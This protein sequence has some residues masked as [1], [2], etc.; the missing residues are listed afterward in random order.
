MIIATKSSTNGKRIQAEAIKVRRSSS[1][2]AG[3]TSKCPRVKTR[4]RYSRSVRL[5]R[6]VVRRIQVRL[7]V[8]LLILL[9]NHWAWAE[10]V[11]RVDPLLRRCGKLSLLIRDSPGYDMIMVEMVQQELGIKIHLVPKPWKR[12][13]LE[14]QS[15]LVMVSST[16]VFFTGTPRHGRLSYA[17]RQARPNKRMLRYR[18]SL[19]RLRGSSVCGMA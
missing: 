1:S 9:C 11:G 16:P 6:T 14:M 17:G 19:Y 13:L 2:L 4:S 12:C 8:L 10:P 5:S 3:T 7:F 18:Y 15:N